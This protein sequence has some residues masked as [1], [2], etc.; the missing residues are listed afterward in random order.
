MHVHTHAHAHDCTIPTRMSM[1]MLRVTLRRL[2][3]SRSSFLSLGVGFKTIG[4]NGTEYGKGDVAEFCTPVFAAG[5]LAHLASSPE[6]SQGVRDLRRR[7]DRRHLAAAP[8]SSTVTP[9]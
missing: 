8:M 2:F 3:S 6:A 9:A 5:G 7:I 1:H 4:S